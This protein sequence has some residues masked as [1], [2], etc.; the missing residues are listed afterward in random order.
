MILERQSLWLTFIRAIHITLF[1][2]VFL[3]NL[4]WQI[5]C[6]CCPFNLFSPYWLTFSL[7]L[8]LQTRKQTTIYCF[9]LLK[10]KKKTTLDIEASEETNICELGQDK[11]IYL[12][13]FSKHSLSILVKLIN[14]LNSIF[15]SVNEAELIWSLSRLKILLIQYFSFS[16]LLISI[17][18]KKLVSLI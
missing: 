10:S 12:E 6:Y 11:A 2:S 14:V 16:K 17:F 1:H 4:W 7:N 18:I 15:F 9:V 3:V 13:V 5:P 8:K